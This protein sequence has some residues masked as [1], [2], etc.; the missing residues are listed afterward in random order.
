[1]AQPQLVHQQ[2]LCIRVALV[3]GGLWVGG[4]MLVTAQ[5]RMDTRVVVQMLSSVEQGRTVHAQSTVLAAAITSVCVHHI[6]DP[7]FAMLV[8]TRHITSVDAHSNSMRP[9]QQTSACPSF[10]CPSHPTTPPLGVRHI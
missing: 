2:R 7:A 3:C 9:S 4:C 8:F 5:S 6:T 1:M 10:K